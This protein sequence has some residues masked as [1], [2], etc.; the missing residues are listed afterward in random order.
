MRIKNL[1]TLL[2]AAGLCGCQH[3]SFLD[4]RLD[5][6]V[7]EYSLTFPDYDPNGLMGGML[8]DR[9]TLTFNNNKQV[10]ELSAGM[11]IFKTAMISD[12][13][14]R[15]MNYHMSMMSRKIVAHLQ[16]RDLDLFNADRETP[17]IIHTNDMDTIAG[18]P[19]K[20]AIAIFDRIDQPE[21][22]IWYTEEIEMK[23]P[24]WFGP[25]AEIKGVLMRYELYQHGIRMRL[26]ALT[27]T[28]GSVDKAKFK[29]KEEYQTVPPGVLH[30]ELAE[31]LGTF[32]M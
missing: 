22:E 16:N 19:C 1:W 26:E 6:G 17:T 25:F 3:V 14:A 24:N 5:E 10:A 20:R 29:V 28:P 12:N 27:V 18:Y 21:I 4:G 31:V 8:P 13:G 15:A 23:D 11:G 9:T 7:I 2:L 30:Q 32:N